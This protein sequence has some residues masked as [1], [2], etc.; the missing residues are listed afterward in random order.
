MKLRLL[1]APLLAE[2]LRT[3]GQMV[4]ESDF[5]GGKRVQDFETAFAE[6]CETPFSVGVSSGTSALTLALL[7]HGIGPGDEVITVANTFIATVEAILAT[8]ATP[9]LTDPSRDSAMMDPS[10]VERAM[11]KKTKAILPVH[12]FG[13]PVDLSRLALTEKAIIQDCA[14][15]HGARWNDKPLSHFGATQTYSFYPGKNLG[16]WGD[17]GA[18]ATDSEEVRDTVYRLRDHG[19]NRG[20][21][22]VHAF[23]RG[24]T[25][26]LDAIQA[27][28][29]T[30]KLKDLPRQNEERRNIFEKY[31][32]ALSGI[33]GVE[34]IRPLPGA[35]SVHHLCVIRSARRA[36]LQA[37]L[38]N[39]GVQTGI[40]YPVALNRQPCFT[41]LAF[42]PMPNA[43]AL[44]D[45]V[46]SLPFFPGITENEIAYVADHVRRFH[47]A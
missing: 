17:G 34:L 25:E 35:T 2:A 18:V 43:E 42:P 3:I 5:V 30:L 28:I 1:H 40:H 23:R 8:G 36:K 16:A 47:Q 10:A 37:H 13:N 29:L 32:E 38:S 6:Y 45:E 31:A 24:S 33:A 20:E 41:S 46:L 19:R 12:L 26:R 4:E 9:V 21:K 14:Q 11:T 7:A 39:A 27:A 44:A 15:A 22:Y